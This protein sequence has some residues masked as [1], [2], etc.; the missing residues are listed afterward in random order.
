MPP[1]KRDLEWGGADQQALVFDDEDAGELVR[2]FN[3][4]LQGHTFSVKLV[5]RDPNYDL[6]LHDPKTKKVVYAAKGWRDYAKDRATSPGC[7]EA[8]GQ[9]F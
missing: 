8:T 7:N 4:R 5:R 2:L 3:S 6:T 1:K 9:L